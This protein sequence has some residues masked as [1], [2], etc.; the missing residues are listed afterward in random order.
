MHPHCTVN[1]TC[2]ASVNGLYLHLQTRVLS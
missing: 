2:F 1:F